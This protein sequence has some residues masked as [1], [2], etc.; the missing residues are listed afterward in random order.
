MVLCRVVLLRN[1]YLEEVFTLLKLLPRAV[2]V[3][4]LSAHDPLQLW[5]WEQNFNV[6]SVLWGSGSLHWK[7]SR[8]L[9][10]VRPL[11]LS[12]KFKFLTVTESSADI[13]PK[14]ILILALIDSH[15]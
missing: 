5:D 2:V 10:Y 4:V 1:F 11:R 6:L 9:C 8:V 13:E 15:S 14:K 7:I 3:S 12:V